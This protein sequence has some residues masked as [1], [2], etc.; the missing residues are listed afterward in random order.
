[1]L[2]CAFDMGDM[3]IGSLGMV[4]GT[5][6]EQS[7]VLYLHVPYVSMG[8]FFLTV[9]FLSV[10]TVFIANLVLKQVISACNK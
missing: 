5:N 4:T 8:G 2:N 6:L 7:F 1:M 3:H 9:I 10:E